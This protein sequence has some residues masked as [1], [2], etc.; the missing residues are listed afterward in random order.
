MFMEFNQAVTLAVFLFFI[1]FAL[2]IMFAP[3]VYRLK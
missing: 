1:G 3:R 2:G